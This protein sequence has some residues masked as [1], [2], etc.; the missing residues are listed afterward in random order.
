MINDLCFIIITSLSGFD[1][2]LSVFERSLSNIKKFHSDSQVLIINNG[3][4]ASRKNIE[5]VTNKVEIKKCIIINNLSE[6]NSYTT[7][8]VE[9]AIRHMKWCDTKNI[10]FKRIVFLQGTTAIIKK[11]P[12]DSGIDGFASFYDFKMAFDGKEQKKWVEDNCFKILNKIIYTDSTPRGCF[13]P[14][15]IMNLECFS[16]FIEIEFFTKINTFTKLQACALER[17]FPIIA[18]NLDIKISCLSG[19]IHFYPNAHSNRIASKE[20][21]EKKGY[22]LEKVWGHFF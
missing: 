1:W 21:L 5:F 9:A 6:N 11:L 19:D 14:N 20:S 13:G 18:K 16:K 4:D 12:E 10:T 3:K 8:G 17:I 15:F 7:G 22:F 2:E